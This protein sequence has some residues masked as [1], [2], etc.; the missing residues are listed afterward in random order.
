M[1][2]LQLE[3][4]EPTN[5]SKFTQA[6]YTGSLSCTS[7]TT[8]TGGT[9]VLLLIRSSGPLGISS[10]ST[11]VYKSK[12]TSLLPMYVR[13]ETELVEYFQ[14]EVFPPPCPKAQDVWDG[15]SQAA[16]L[17]NLR[18]YSRSAPRSPGMQCT[19]RGTQ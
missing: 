12:E 13:P 1:L 18:R 11:A 17:L 7:M 19:V 8:A 6:A 4:I 10:A 3:V 16:Q 15:S 5:N 2:A 14:V 9:S